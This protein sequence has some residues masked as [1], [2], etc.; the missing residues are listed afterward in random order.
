MDALFGHLCSA[1]IF[2]HDHEMMKL[3]NGPDLSKP[4]KRSL[5]SP[6][7][8]ATRLPRSQMTESFSRGI[9]IDPATR[10]P[11]D[12]TVTGQTIAELTD[13]QSHLAKRPRLA[14]NTQNTLGEST[15]REVPSTTDASTDTSHDRRIQAIRI[16]FEHGLDGSSSHTASSSRIESAPISGGRST[17]RILEKADVAQG[18]K[19]TYQAAWKGLRTV[20]RVITTSKPSRVSANLCPKPIASHKTKEPEKGKL[21]SKPYS[22]IQHDGAAKASAPSPSNHAAYPTR[23]DFDMSTG[24]YKCSWL[25][26]EEIFLSMKRLRQHVIDC[27]MVG[28]SL[29]GATAY[30]CL[31]EGCAIPKITY[32]SNRDS[33]EEHMDSHH[34]YT[35][36]DHSQMPRGRHDAPTNNDTLPKLILRPPK[37][38]GTDDLAATSKISSSRLGVTQEETIELSDTTSTSSQESFP[39]TI[40]KLKKSFDEDR[41]GSTDAELVVVEDDNG[42]EC[43]EEEETQ[44]SLPDSVFDSQAS[45]KMH[46]DRSARSIQTRKAAYK[47]AKGLGGREWATYSLYGAVCSN[48]SYHQEEV[49]LG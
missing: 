22:E 19:S 13:I 33:W 37:E 18:T 1:Q 7:S 14:R 10:S 43:S 34:F 26:C 16:D 42:G 20:P 38:M 31:W 23:N 4:E 2:T 36:K 12:I 9:S 41:S 30:G 44:L 39:R 32:H 46:R 45:T 11:E 48:S 27:H 47:A 49:E 28:V 25:A 15:S 17:S 21:Q 6:D 29:E 8:D 5:G 35:R 3:A 40:A 24:H